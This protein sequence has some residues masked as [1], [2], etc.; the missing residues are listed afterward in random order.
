MMSSSEIN[1]IIFWGCVVIGCIVY[2]IIIWS[3]IAYRKTRGEGK[4]LFHK[5]TMT[6]IAWT[7]IPLLLIIAMAYP[8]AT[9]L[10]RVYSGDS[11]QENSQ[12]VTEKE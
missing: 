7:V 2:G 1:M 11:D 5:N 10:T 4:S 8:A 3:L 6:E 9:I 12:T